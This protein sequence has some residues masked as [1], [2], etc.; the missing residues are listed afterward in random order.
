MLCDD[1]P[2][3]AG[4]KQLCE[5]AQKY[6]SQ[7][8]VEGSETLLFFDPT[9]LDY[10]SHTLS[11]PECLLSELD[12]SEHRILRKHGLT[13]RQRECADLFFFKKMT[14]RQIADKLGI[15]HPMVTKHIQKAVILI[16]KGVT[17]SP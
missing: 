16:K 10:L 6:A 14:H 7:D 11:Y 17:K 4:C 1:C 9:D 5:D 2:K 3:R 8:H 15:S 12:K 13:K